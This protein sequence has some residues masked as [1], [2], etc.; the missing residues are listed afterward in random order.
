MAT[1]RARRLANNHV[2][3]SSR[4]TSK[5]NQH[6]DVNSADPTDKDTICSDILSLRNC[7]SF[8]GDLGCIAQHFTL[9]D[10]VVDYA[11]AISFIAAG[12][13]WV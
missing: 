4:K 3:K 9:S 6:R 2:E 7:C 1:Q 11:E 12:A 5:K 10:N 8:G 13:Y